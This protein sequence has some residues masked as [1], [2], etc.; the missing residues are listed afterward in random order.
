MIVAGAVGRRHQEDELQRLATLF[1]VDDDLRPVI[2]DIDVT[3]DYIDYFST[4]WPKALL[5]L[6]TI[7][8]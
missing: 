6:K 3:D 8:E 4:T 2:A 1:P 5:K 7:C